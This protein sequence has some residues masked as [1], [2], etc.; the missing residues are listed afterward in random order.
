VVAPPDATSDTDA[1]DALARLGR[2]I[3]ALSSA[4]ARLQE[5]QHADAIPP[6]V[7]AT[8]RELGIESQTSLLDVPIAVPADPRDTAQTTGTL[9]IAYSTIGSGQ[10]RRVERLIGRKTIGM[11]IPLEKVDIFAQVVRTREPCYQSDHNTSMQQI[12]PWLPAPVIGQ[13]A[14]LVHASTSVT[15]P[16][17]SRGRVLGIMSFWGDDLRPEDTHALAA[18]A[19][20]AGVAID[21]TRLFEE[22]RH[23]ADELE[24]TFASMS[25]GVAICDLDGHVVRMNEAA[26]R[27][28]GHHEVATE[29][30]EARRVRFALCR[31]DGSPL[32]VDEMPSVRAARGETFNNVECLVDGEDGPETIISVSGTPLR[33]V[34]G[35][36]RGGV[37][38]IRNVTQ[39]RRLERRTYKALQA[40]LEMASILAAPTQRPAT[41]PGQAPGG[42]MD[43]ASAEWNGLHAALRQ[44]CRLSIGV[45]GCDRVAISLVDP[46]SLLITP[47][48][49]A[50]LT[51][52]QAAFWLAEQQARRERQRRL[53]EHDQDV[54]RRLQ[55][56]EAVVVDVTQP[57]YARQ[58][59]PYGARSV[60]AVP[61]MVAGRLTGVLALD[62]HVQ[63]PDAS[64]AVYSPDEIALAEGIARLAALAVERY[65]LERVAAEV[66]ALRAANA[67]KEEFLS[68][69]SHELK[70]PLTVLQARAQATRRRLERMGQH[71]AAAQFTPIQ[72]ALDRILALVRELLDASRVEAGRL[73]LQLEPCDLG[74]LAR[75]VVDEAR[76][77][78][79]RAISLEGADA[80]DLW[81]LGDAERLAQVLTNLLENANKYSPPETPIAVRILREPAGQGHVILTVTDEGIGIP[82]DEVAHVFE[83]FYRARTA[84]TRQY[85]GLGL[86]LHI[87][88]T[89]VERHG[90]SIWADSPGPG[91]GST[92][93]M[94]LPALDPPPAEA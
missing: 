69:A 81:T 84:S 40:L 32:P 82:T 87:A 68:I 35:A 1:A 33:G 47:I 29:S 91:Q 2:L 21:N 78:M 74:K 37:V 8:L 27:I 83:R 4:A 41:A 61:L 93:S 34:D 6:L 76:E 59:N 86:G 36:T 9:R 67:L 56:G 89:I 23:R 85:G 72:A 92:F 44:I 52:A 5:A 25:A 58:P 24:A 71:E 94:A 17:L 48:A 90:G 43:S 49:V 3:A 55:R 70:T 65:Q 26:Q 10:L 62:H 45:M 51:P 38:V 50:G 66:E 28:T 30:P 42:N 64:P 31:P 53:D 75:A 54:A 7:G 39:M 12:F 77:V 57:P 88:A 11:T 13:L 22:S 16:L 63:P 60:L 46:D 80:P 73:D 15:A 14:R 18:F 79:V 20:Q 19:R